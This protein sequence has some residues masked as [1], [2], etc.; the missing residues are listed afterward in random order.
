MKINTN[1]CWCGTA[2]VFHIRYDRGVR[3]HN[4]SLLVRRSF[5]TF[6]GSCAPVQSNCNTIAS[7]LQQLPG[8]WLPLVLKM[9]ND[10]GIAEQH[11]VG[12][13]VGMI[14]SVF[15]CHY[16]YSFCC[17]GNN[18]SWLPFMEASECSVHTDW[19]LF[20]LGDTT[21]KWFFLRRVESLQH[22]FRL[23]NVL[24]WKTLSLYKWR[25]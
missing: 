23:S 18:T 6:G 11:N 4:M 5:A 13:K 7:E 25:S 9:Y 21:T 22:W 2:K 1:W 19:R 16:R 12:K 8:V 14:A 17:Y 15:C 24:I 20:L 3:D 10:V